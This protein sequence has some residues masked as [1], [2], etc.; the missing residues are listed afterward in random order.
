[1]PFIGTQIALRNPEVRDW[2]QA[3]IDLTSLWIGAAEVGLTALFSGVASALFGVVVTV[4]YIDNLKLGT[5]AELEKAPE[6]RR[7]RR[8]R[9]ARRTIREP[10]N[11][12]KFMGHWKFDE[13]DG[14]V[15]EEGARRDYGVG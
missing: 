2:L 1:M 9:L 6:R 14:Y 8:A 12:Q 5:A 4:F 11:N 7:T 13:A 3:R 10:A 15:A